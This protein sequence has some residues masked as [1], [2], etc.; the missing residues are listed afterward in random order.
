MSVKP[1][2]TVAGEVP[3]ELLEALSHV[4][5]EYRPEIVQV[6]I[7]VPPVPTPEMP[8]APAVTEKPKIT[9]AGEVPKEL[10][11]ALEYIPEE[12]KPE[13]VMVTGTVISSKT[14]VAPPLVEV[15]V[16]PLTPSLPWYVAWL[17]PVLDYG[18][19]LTE[20][21]VN[22]FASSFRSIAD[23]ADAIKDTFT[24]FWEN[25]LN[26]QAA[27]EKKHRDEAIASTVA[28]TKE[29]A[30]GSP[31]WEFEYQYALSEGAKAAM[32]KAEVAVP[33]PKDWLAGTPPSEAATTVD[34]L[35]QWLSALIVG[36][37]AFSAVAE[38]ASLGME[39]STI[40]LVH[41][42]LDSIGAIDMLKFMAM[43]PWEN[44][45][46]RTYEYELNNTH[47]NVL[48]SV[49]DMV[50][51]VIKQKITVLDFK[52]TMGYM[53]YADEWSQRMLDANYNLPSYAQVLNAHYRGVVK[54]D[55]L[56]TYRDKLA[57]DPKYKDVWDA[58][59][60]VIPDYS[61][62]TNELVKEVID[63]PTYTKYLQWHGFNPEWSKRIWDAHFYP[64]SLGDIL[65]A[66]RRGIIT[67]ADVDR[68]MII[69]D[70]DPRFKNVF[71][72]RKYA[73]PSLMIT[74]MMYETGAIGAD[75][76]PDLV[77]RQ[78]YSPEHEKAVT[79]YVLTFQERLWRRRYLVSLSTAASLGA[80]SMD[81]VRKEVVAAGYSEGVAEWMIKAAEMRT[82]IASY[83]FEHPKPKL[84]SIGNLKD[85]YL[86]D[87]IDADKL[88]T[89]LLQRGYLLDEVDLLISLMDEDKVIAKEGR[90]VIALS[91]PQLLDAYR[92]GEIT[93]DVILI[94]L[95]TRGLAL[96]E[97]ETLVKT[98]EKQWGIIGG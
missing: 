31:E 98:K 9:I 69:V 61:E 22:F 46:F 47:R 64:P 14:L 34:A 85:A 86:L 55:E 67:E 88:R 74:R 71:D 33:K 82:K 78:G 32:A 89:E 75:E 35:K 72:T 37:Y 1:K 21:V 20:S 97:V 13:I 81:T 30:K 53:G 83:R 73:D 40:Q 77:H 10:L 76:V 4:P 24:N 79:D 17:Q 52:K 11:D 3:K 68:L 96:D 80:A 95:Q 94:K 12:Y 27:I 50:S 19:V 7:G 6:S 44:G 5:E 65:T 60:E 84:M 39:E 38:L 58:L 62:L 23:G 45:L 43:K 57:L 56:E 25:V 90:Q 16:P 91:I 36:G 41:D 93:R 92:Y 18:G 49:N 48:P 15:T 66:W 87:K 63:L 70:L 54:P 8:V 42:T 2:I 28:S 59:T 26:N 51:M 29:L